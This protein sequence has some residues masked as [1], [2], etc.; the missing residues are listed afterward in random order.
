MSIIS[1]LSGLSTLSLAGKV[2][3][4]IA[5]GA[6]EFASMLAS[7]GDDSQSSSTSQIGDAVASTDSSSSSKTSSSLDEFMAYMKL[8]PGEKLRKS[9]MDDMDVTQD[10]LNAMPADDRERIEREIAE[11]IKEKVTQQASEGNDVTTRVANL[12]QQQLQRVQA[13]SGTSGAHISLFS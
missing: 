4:G 11:R 8:S 13:S 2:V 5:S 10:Q 9:V 12:A 6:S 3:S 7:A 1:G